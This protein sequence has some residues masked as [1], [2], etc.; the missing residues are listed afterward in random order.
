MPDG[1]LLQPLRGVPLINA[2]DDL[3]VVILTALRASDLTLEKGDVLV[4]AQKVVSKAEGRSVDLRSVT[5]SAR[6]VELAAVT[7]KDARLVELILSESRTV[8]RSRPGVLIVEHRLGLMLAN[9]GIDRSNVEG[10]YRALLLPLD[11]DRSSLMIRRALA[12]KAGVDVGILIIDS[13]GR[14]WR[15]GTIGTAIGAS[16]IPTLLD[17]RGRP[18]L[19]GR[20]LETT[21]VGWADE[22]AGAASLVMGQAGEGRPVILARGLLGA[23]GDGSA[24]ELLRPKDKDLFR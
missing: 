20:A 19:Y 7:R 16:G 9:A 21:E 17:L 10:S 3:A 8:V 11:P 6:A 18:D 4:L 5:P 14:A 22:L 1:L 12:E 2:G 24:S 15:N 13:I 23:A